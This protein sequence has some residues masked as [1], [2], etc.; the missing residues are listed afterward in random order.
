MVSTL[1]YKA[2]AQLF[3]ISSFGL[4][5]PGCAVGTLGSLVET[6]IAPDSQI[7]QPSR[8]LDSSEASVGQRCD[9]SILAQLPETLPS[10]LCYPGAVLLDVEAQGNTQQDVNGQ[11]LQSRNIFQTRWETSQPLVVVQ[12]FYKNF[13]LSENW[14]VTRFPHELNNAGI[15]QAVKG[16]TRI[17]LRFPEDVPSQPT[18]DSRELIS[19][20]KIEPV[21]YTLNYRESLG[22]KLSTPNRFE[23]K[24]GYQLGSV[25]A[26]FQH[27]MEPDKVEGLFP[28]DAPASE[29]LRQNQEP[30]VKLSEDLDH[31]E[32]IDLDS[33]PLE[34]QGYVKDLLY[35]ELLPEIENPDEAFSQILSSSRFNEA[36]TRREFARWL[37]MIN[38]RLHLNRPS[39]QLRLADPLS[40]PAFEDILPTDP[41]FPIIQG[42]AEAG[43]I[44]S[45]LSNDSEASSFSFR[46]DAPLT[47]EVLVAWKI[48]LD[49]RKAVP[50]ATIESIQDT[51]G[52]QDT[53]TMTPRL[54][55]AIAADYE[56]GD[57]SNLRRA[58]GYTLLFQPQKTVTRAEA[59][60]ALWYF[61]TEE[62]G[63]SAADL[64]EE[65]SES[66]IVLE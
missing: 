18:Q 12:E 45:I 27:V 35:L 34:L 20:T 26:N 2:I 25:A 19:I 53:A 11:S 22:L 55:G 32:V 62:D 5:S 49:I 4:L 64:L 16:R 8:Q 65:V 56:N 36:I 44:P 17:T 3:F 50:T 41:D 29:G 59:A 39:K 52:F 40:E 54:F 14:Q 42:L 38:N 15:L 43:I 31:S 47:R 7:Q 57:R 23:L 46:S 1:R 13:F 61:G 33:V 6:S 51:W 28:E 63:I 9:D 24:S 21:E 10:A 48:P 58:F 60:A 66:D 30:T 37:V